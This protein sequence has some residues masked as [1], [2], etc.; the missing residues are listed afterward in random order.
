MWYT[1]SKQRKVTMRTFSVIGVIVLFFLSTACTTSGE[2]LTAPPLP[3]GMNGENSSDTSAGQCHTNMRKL[4]GQA[5]IFYAENDRYPI[6]QGEMGMTGVTCPECGEEYEIIGG[7]DHF[8]VGCPLPFSPNHG[9]IDDGVPSWSEKPQTP[10][11]EQNV[12]RANMRT[13]SSQVAIF[14]AT[15]NRYPRDMEELGMSGIVCPTCAQEY[16]LTD[17]DDHFYIE[18]P[19]PFSPDHGNIDDGVVSWLDSGN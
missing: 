4:A 19:L 1:G 8:Y 14:F 17:G 9:N 10:E 12:C 15:H 16:E 13:I 2:N 3:T 18:C 7:G 11:E 5:V 6:D